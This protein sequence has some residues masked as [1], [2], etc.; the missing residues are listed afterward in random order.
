MT[1]S[2]KQV[3]D[4]QELLRAHTELRNLLAMHGDRPLRLYAN[5]VDNRSPQP[6]LPPGIGSRVLVVSIALVEAELAELG[7]EPDKSLTRDCFE[8]GG[9]GKVPIG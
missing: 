4:A 9:K 3:H 7:V 6:Y 8:C 1:M 5:E 2:P